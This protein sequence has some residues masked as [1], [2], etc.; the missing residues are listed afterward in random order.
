MKLTVKKWAALG[1]S[2]AQIVQFRAAF[3]R[4]LD[5]PERGKQ[6][7]YVLYQM[8][9]VDLDVD[10]YLQ[11]T[12]ESGTAYRWSKSGLSQTKSVYCRSKPQPYKIVR[13]VLRIERYRNGNLRKIEH[14]LD[15]KL[16]D[17]RFDPAVTGWHP[18]GAVRLIEHY[19]RGKRCDKLMSAA[20]R[21]WDADGKLLRELHYF[22][23]E[24][25]K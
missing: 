9:C 14:R 4:G 23:G 5:L 20:C 12:C 13:P 18:N 1:A 21:E 2:E 24:P 7:R 15:G 17:T 6:R 3:P 19:R 22:A 25:I 16:N 11:T 10:W 8:A